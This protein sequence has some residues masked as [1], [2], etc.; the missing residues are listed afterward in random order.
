MTYC[1]FRLLETFHEAPV[2]QAGEDVTVDGEDLD[3]VPDGSAAMKHLEQV[4]DSTNTSEDG[5]NDV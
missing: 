1:Q 4:L 3:S 2:L 5:G